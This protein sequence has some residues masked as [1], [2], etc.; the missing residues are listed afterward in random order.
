MVRT[1]FLVSARIFY[2][3]QDFYISDHSLLSVI[4]RKEHEPTNF[5]WEFANRWDTY[6]VE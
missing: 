2:N 5:L 1:L 6:I 3:N 4:R